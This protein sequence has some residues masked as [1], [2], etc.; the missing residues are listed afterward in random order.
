MSI[1]LSIQKREK[2]VAQFFGLPEDMFSQMSLPVDEREERLLEWECNAR[3]IASCVK[4]DRR[5]AA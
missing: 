3:R 5:S 4:S 1:T 2:Y